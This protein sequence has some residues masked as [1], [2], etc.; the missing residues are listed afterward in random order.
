MEGLKDWLAKLKMEAKQMLR[1]NK[2]A[3]SELQSNEFESG[4]IKKY[5]TCPFITAI[6]FPQAAR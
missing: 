4:M 3:N 6:P 2:I 5:C 1:T